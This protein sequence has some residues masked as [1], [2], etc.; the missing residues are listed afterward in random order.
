MIVLV[1]PFLQFHREFKWAHFFRRLSHCK[2]QLCL[3]IVKFSLMKAHR[4]FLHVRMSWFCWLTHNQ[5]LFHCN[6]S[7]TMPSNRKVKRQ[8]TMRWMSI[9]LRKGGSNYDLLWLFLYI[10]RRWSLI[11]SNAYCNQSIHI[12]IVLLFPKQST[13]C[14][15]NGYVTNNSISMLL[16]NT[17]KNSM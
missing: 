13:V 7:Y 9:H 3:I 6:D 11:I 2:L 12:M 8:S 1:G 4:N 5:Q 10:N 14:V 16:N 17:K 15:W